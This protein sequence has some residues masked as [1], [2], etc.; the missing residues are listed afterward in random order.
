MTAPTQTYVD[1]A[2]AA[3]SGA[4]TIGDPYGDLQYALNQVTRDSTNGD[5]FNVK[6][7]TDEILSSALS[8]TT[9][10]TPTAT[11]PLL[12]R[13]YT[14]AADDGGIG[15]VSGNGSVQCIDFNADGKDYVWLIDM[16]FHNT[17]SN[18]IVELRFYGAVINCEFNNSSSD[19]IFVS[20]GGKVIGCHVHDV[21]NYGIRLAGNTGTLALSNFL[22]NGPTNNFVI[23]IQ[24]ITANDC[25]VIGNVIKMGSTGDG[26]WNQDHDLAVINNTI[27]AN[28]STGTGIDLET[29]GFR[30]RIVI[31]NYVEGFSGVGG[32]GYDYNTT[33][34]IISLHNKAYNNTTNF[35]DENDR[36]FYT[37]NDGALGS[38]PLTDPSNN[39]FSVDEILRSLGFPSSFNG[40]ST[41]QYLDIG[42]AQRKEPQ[43]LLRVQ[44]E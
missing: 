33:S 10:G 3:D 35:V 38:S 16:H 11:A 24:A 39:D 23:G 19:G 2:I 12:I 17:G 41:N 42:A 5:Q 9:Y 6:A 22:E 30:N 1:P 25:L 34:G 31:N 4:G 37:A 36:N 18:P 14:S 40:A 7:G 43:G 20:T 27:Y 15:G 32:Q 26:I 8:L 28:G 29:G 21:G 44:I 13:G